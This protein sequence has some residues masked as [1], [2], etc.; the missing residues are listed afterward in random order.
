MQNGKLYRGNMKKAKLDKCQTK[1]GQSLALIPALHGALNFGPFTPL[2][3]D[4]MVPF[5]LFAGMECAHGVVSMMHTLSGQA[6]L[7]GERI[8][9]DG[10]VGYIETDRG[11]SFPSAYLWTQCLWT[12]PQPVSLMLAV[13]AIPLPVGRF[14][15]CI[16]AICCGGREYRLATYRG[17]S[18]ER[19]SGEGAAVRQARFRLEA[20]VLSA[21]GPPL[22]AP[23]QGQMTRSIR[24]S[25]RAAVR[26][27]FR[28]RDRLLFDHTDDS[29]SFEFS[30]VEG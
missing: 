23:V 19:W 22:R 11:R 14:T 28:V 7:N 8:D 27:R 21:Q 12:D 30:A 25:L 10:G 17:A 26:Y 2:H 20:D 15:G 24:E 1:A 6:V 29:A 4:I 18:P 13:A 9:F 16:C 5:R 3:S